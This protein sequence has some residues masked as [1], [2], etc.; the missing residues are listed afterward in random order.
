MKPPI[1]KRKR[2]AREKLSE[3]TEVQAFR[4]PNIKHQKLGR[5]GNWG[6]YW[7]GTSL[8]ILDPRMKAYRYLNTLIHEML[9]LFFPDLNER[10]VT[11]LGDKFAKQIWKRRY[12]RIDK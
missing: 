5:E 6:E 9:H 11:L 4:N 8:I 12:R 1:K 10:T 2:S 7:C 3:T